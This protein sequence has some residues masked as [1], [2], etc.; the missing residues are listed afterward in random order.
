MKQLGLSPGY[1]KMLPNNYEFPF[2]REFFF[3]GKKIGMPALS[4]H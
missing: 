4:Q 2:C 1:E 3:P